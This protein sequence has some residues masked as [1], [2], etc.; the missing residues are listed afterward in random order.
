MPAP[1]ASTLL[2]GPLDIDSCP[3]LSRPA[4]RRSSPGGAGAGVGGGRLR[5]LLVLLKP[6]SFMPLWVSGLSEKTLALG[7]SV[8]R[9]NSLL[10]QGLPY[11]RFL[12]RFVLLPTGADEEGRSAAAGGLR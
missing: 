7:S 5:V 6:K 2:P 3:P 9:G 1:N 8:N 4:K 11:L 10:P 12:V